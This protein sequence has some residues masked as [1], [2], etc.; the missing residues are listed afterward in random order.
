MPDGSI[1]QVEVTSCGLNDGSLIG[2]GEYLVSIACNLEGEDGVAFY[3]ICDDQRN[4]HPYFTQ[5]RQDREDNPNQYC[6]F[7]KW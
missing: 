6:E 4:N 7:A 5:E 1:Q 3:P 2:I